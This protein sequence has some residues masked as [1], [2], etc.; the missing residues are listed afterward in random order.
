M[1]LRALVRNQRYKNSNNC[2]ISEL[3][4]FP[5]RRLTSFQISILF[6][7]RLSLSFSLP[8]VISSTGFPVV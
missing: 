3:L 7:T 2:R 4:E 8:N 1:R 6:L 5:Q